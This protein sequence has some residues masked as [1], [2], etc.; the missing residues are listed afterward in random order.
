[1][2]PPYDASMRSSPALTVAMAA[3]ALALSGCDKLTGLVKSEPDAAVVAVV[4]AA[5]AAA[6]DAAA[7]AAVDASV[8]PTTTAKPVVVA[9]KDGGPGDASAAVAD[10]A[11][12]V[13][14]GVDAAITPRRATRGAFTCDSPGCQCEPG[15]TCD[16]TC[17]ATGACN[18]VVREIATATIH[19]GTSPVTL[20]CNKGAT[21]H[22]QGGAGASRTRCT[23]A[24]CDVEC[25]S[26]ACNLTCESGGKCSIAKKGS[27]AVKCDGC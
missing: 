2:R 20:Q 1:M 22:V 24:K 16:I 9:R 14:A 25:H 6:V 23:G 17:P 8:A 19:G 13:D 10:A 5:P 15:V 27:G 3:L 4:D 21:C 26:G 7:A 11:A 18:V 12:P